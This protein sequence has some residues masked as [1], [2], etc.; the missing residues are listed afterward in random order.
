MRPAGIVQAALALI[1]AATAIG[2]TAF[3]RPAGPEPAQK[4]YVLSEIAPHDRD[5]YRD[6]LQNVLPIIERHGGRI[7]VSP[8]VPAKAV[9]G[10]AL[11]G[12]LAIIEFPSPEAR[13]AFWNVP[14][15]QPWKTLRQAN[16]TSRI[17]HIN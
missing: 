2:S 14:G 15:Y 1:L 16:A 5:A 17:I 7:V 10:R 12:N 6:Y 8:F 9:E 11:E 3:A 4:A 13:D